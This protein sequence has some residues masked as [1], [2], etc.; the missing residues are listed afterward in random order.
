MRVRF[1]QT[2]LAELI[3]IHDY[4]AKDN[5]RAAKTVILRIEQVIARIGEFPHIARAIDQSGVRVFPAGP[6]PYLVFYTVE[7]DSVTIRNVRHVRR[8]RPETA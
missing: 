7:S 6:F 3:E 4:I 5:L 8:K 2:A 1:T